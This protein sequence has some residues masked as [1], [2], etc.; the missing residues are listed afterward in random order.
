M[1]GKKKAG[2]K[3]G[4]LALKLCS[5]ALSSALLTCF[6][7][8]ILTKRF[9]AKCRRKRNKHKLNLLFHRNNYES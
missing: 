6:P 8:P 3:M 4:T 7:I 9:T 1:H 2:R 5:F